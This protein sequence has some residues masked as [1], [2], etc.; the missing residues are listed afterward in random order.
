MK[1]L[2]DYRQTMKKLDG[3]IIREKNC[4]AVIDS[5]QTQWK[6]RLEALTEWSKEDFRIA[7]T[8]CLATGKYT[9]INALLGERV[10]PASWMHFTRAIVELHYGEDKK[11]I[12]HYGEGQ[13]CEGCGSER[14]EVDATEEN[15]KRYLTQW[16]DPESAAEPVVLPGKIELYWP[17]PLLKS[18]VVIADVPIV[19]GPCDDDADAISYLSTSDVIIFTVNGCT[20]FTS[21]ERNFLDS[22]NVIG[23]RNIF[24]ACNFWDQ[25]REEEQKTIEKQKEY[26][27]SRGMKYT[28]LGESAIHFLATRDG[29]H[30]RNTGDRDLWVESGFEEFERALQDHLI[31]SAGR[32]RIRHVVSG[33]D[34]QADIMRGQARLI[35]GFDRLA[36]VDLDQRL[37]RA[38]SMLDGMER[39]ANM[40]FAE[41]KSKLEG[42]LPGIQSF[43]RGA[44]SDLSRD[45]DLS[46]FTPNTRYPNGIKR[47]N[48]IEM[49]SVTQKII[50]E[51]HTEFRSRLTQAV[52]EL[53]NGL[54]VQLL[55]A[56]KAAVSDAGT[57][58][59][60]ILGKL[61]SLEIYAGLSDGEPA[62]SK[63]GGPTPYL[64]LYAGTFGEWILSDPTDRSG[65]AVAQPEVQLGP[66][67]FPSLGTGFGY[68]IIFQDP[69]MQMIVMGIANLHESNEARLERVRNQTLAKLRE[70]YFGEEDGKCFM[71]TTKAVMENVAQL[72][73]RVFA[74]MEHIIVTAFSEKRASLG[75]LAERSGATHGSSEYFTAARKNALEELDALI[76]EARQT[77]RAID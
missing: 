40:C 26:C 46:G 68:P 73:D 27:V 44:L 66:S 39:E 28:D 34:S 65:D 74:E 71:P 43:V 12:L 11:L 59:N 62:S 60:R 1:M 61:N 5:A 22:I 25:V 45:V 31:R 56:Y 7:I 24:F 72:Y 36:A 3:L 21:Y 9:L 17:I 10:L 52:T 75:T 67:M 57:A 32:D 6:D 69:I 41:L 49:Q 4:A 47:L 42:S 35:D 64:I 14:L 20:P 48:A 55:E 18:G 8:G 76:A 77:Q 15:I 29:L 63:P 53:E 19:G 58:L 16:S 37:D 70:L 33:M 38:Y 51:F 23:I 13:G 2:E 30:A 50:M 54:R